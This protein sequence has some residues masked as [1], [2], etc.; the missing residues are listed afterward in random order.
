M[1]IKPIRSCLWAHAWVMATVGMPLN[2][3]DLVWLVFEAVWLFGGSLNC[4]I[5]KPRRRFC[6]QP[7]LTAP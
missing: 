6:A 1:I 3:V 5:L 4:C 2:N 7:G